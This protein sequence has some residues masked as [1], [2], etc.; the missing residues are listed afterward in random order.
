MK[1]SAGMPGCGGG[2]AGGG[3]SFENYKNFLHI[4]SSG[5]TRVFDISSQFFG[6]N[7]SFGSVFKGHGCDGQS[8]F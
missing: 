7:D 8:K 4:F 3:Y 5:H 1:Q 2:A 6:G